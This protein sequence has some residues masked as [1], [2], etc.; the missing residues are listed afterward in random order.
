[1]ILSSLSAS[2]L[3]DSFDSSE[4]SLTM[5]L[6][7]TRRLSVADCWRLDLFWDTLFLLI[8]DLSLP[9]ELDLIGE[10]CLRGP[11]LLF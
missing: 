10:F 8:G 11:A 5:D 4:S 6:F 1:M 7:P 2:F 3:A 9:G